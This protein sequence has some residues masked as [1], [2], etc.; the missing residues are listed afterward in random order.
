MLRFGSPR[1]SFSVRHLAAIAMAA[2]VLLSFVGPASGAVPRAAAPNTPDRPNIVLIYTDDIGYGD[3]GCYGATKV[4]TPHIDR[5]AREG[6]RFT[7]AHSASAVCSPSR[8][9]L[10]T[11]EYPLR[12]NSW[13]AIFSHVGLIIDPAK[14]TIASLLKRK[15][16]ATA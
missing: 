9:A 1:L 11:G 2:A 16:Y 8:Y 5:L 15:G 12:V 10:L 3:V 7:D 6:R 13:T 14:T 4:K